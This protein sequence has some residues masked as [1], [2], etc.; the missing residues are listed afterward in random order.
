M[1]S[2]ESIKIRKMKNPLRNPDK[3]TD[4]NTFIS[5][6]CFYKDKLIFPILFSLFVNQVG[7]KLQSEIKCNLV[8]YKCVYFYSTLGRYSSVNPEHLFSPL[9]FLQIVME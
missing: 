4:Q 7:G 8:K 3:N 6:I 9:F 2:S 1:V 5:P